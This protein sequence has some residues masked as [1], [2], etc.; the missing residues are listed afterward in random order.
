MAAGSRSSAITLADGPKHA[1]QRPR[2]SAPPVG[3]V[4]EHTVRHRPQRRQNLL[5]HDR[6]MGPGVP[7]HYG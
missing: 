5:D 3:A 4:D 6:Q 7:R 1:E 2:V